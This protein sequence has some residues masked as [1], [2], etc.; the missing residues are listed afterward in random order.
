MS[1]LAPAAQLATPPEPL[2]KLHRASCI[3]GFTARAISERDEGDDVFLAE[4]LRTVE[5]LILEAMTQM[6]REA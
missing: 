1:T 5:G 6:E 3:V 4:T 2:D